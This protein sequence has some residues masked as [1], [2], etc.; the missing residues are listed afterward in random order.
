MFRQGVVF[1]LRNNITNF[2]KN[3]VVVADSSRCLLLFLLYLAVDLPLT[4]L[5]RYTNVDYGSDFPLLT[6]FRAGNAP[7]LALFIAIVIFLIYR[8]L[9]QLDWPDM[10]QGRKIKLFILALCSILSWF[11]ITTEYNF[12]FSQGYYLEKSTLLLLTV[13]LFWRP[14]FIIPWLIFAFLLLWQLQHPSL[15]NGSHFPHKLQVLHILTL[16]CAWV[17]FHTLFRHSRSRDFLFLSAC[18]IASAYW[19]PALEKLLIRWVYSGELY[20]MLLNSHAHGWLSFIDTDRYSRIFD[21]LRPMDLWIRIVVMF[22]EAGCL[23][24]AYR[25]AFTTSIL[26]GLSVFHCGVFLLF[27]YFFWTWIFLNLSFVFLLIKL[28]NQPNSDFFTQHHLIFG[29]ALIITG[30]FWCYPSSLG[31]IDGRMTYTYRYTAVTENDSR[32]VIPFAYFEPYG[33]VFT[34]ANFSYTVNTHKL[35]PNPYGSTNRRFAQL[36]IE[37]E[38]LEDII[39]IEN[40]FGVNRYDENKKEI[41]ENFV[42]HFILNKN[43][44]PDRSNQ[45]QRFAPPRQFWTHPRNPQLPEDETIKEL[46][47]TEVTTFYDGTKSREI[48]T[49]EMMRIKID[50]N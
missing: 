46:I 13:L 49:I 16:F 21:L 34:M 48:R 39:T 5:F 14:F 45:L 2:L 15:N 42:K 24:I 25:R 47:M 40:K 20:L 28:K 18:L 8:G 30:K 43:N 3:K 32:Y 35:L 11:L 27:G 23:F 36:L 9:T 17:I 33:D 37:A 1:P 7:W 41:F 12:Y 10:D 29:I 38:D 26:L 6:I 44:N 19:A 22:L 50:V 31:W 4:R